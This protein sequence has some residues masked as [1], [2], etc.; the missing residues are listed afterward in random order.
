MPARFV[1]LEK[2]CSSPSTL[3]YLYLGGW[4][5]VVVYF[6]E[7]GQE[8]SHSPQGLVGEVVDDPE[9]VVQPV[10]A[11]VVVP[12]PGLATELVELVKLTKLQ[13]GV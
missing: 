4:V 1:S 8:A 7:A 6:G 10:V 12:A 13:E 2:V 9:F 11:V 5:F 3:L